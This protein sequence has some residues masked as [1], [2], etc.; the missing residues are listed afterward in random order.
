MKYTKS[1]RL[2]SNRLLF[3][4]VLLILLGLFIGLFIPMMTNPRM[5]LTA[6]LEGVMNG[7]LLVIL[8]LI[9]NRIILND[10]WLTYTFW[11]TLYGS[12]ANFVAVF[13][14]AL[15]GAGKMMPIAG[16]KEGTAVIEGLISFL[17]ITLALAMI[18][19]C[20]VI[21]TGLYRNLNQAIDNDQNNK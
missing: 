5:G 9:W 11:L 6:H 1:K 17:L 7:M 10:R 2:Q 19:V 18:F 15:T 3:L 12:F 16:G 21:L 8:G 14:A 4:G 13:I 20:I